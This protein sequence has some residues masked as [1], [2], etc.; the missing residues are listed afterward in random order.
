MVCDIER[1][2][3]LTKA[4]KKGVRVNL[5]KLQNSGDRPCRLFDLR[6]SEMMNCIKSALSTVNGEHIEFNSVQFFEDVLVMGEH[7]SSKYSRSHRKSY[8]LVRDEEKDSFYHSVANSSQPR[9]GSFSSFRDPEEL[10]L[11]PVRVVRY[12][13]VSYQARGSMCVTIFALVQFYR[14]I[15]ERKTWL[16]GDIYDLYSSNFDN[17]LAYSEYKLVCIDHL[18]GKFIPGVFASVD[19]RGRTLNHPLNI[20][21]SMSVDMVVLRNSLKNIF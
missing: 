4:T 5:R 1:L 3:P 10:L 9:Y 7:Y 19:F 11:H 14:P 12:L 15:V 17:T 8:V 16:F 6:P 2:P 13:S 21:D 18:V 20:K